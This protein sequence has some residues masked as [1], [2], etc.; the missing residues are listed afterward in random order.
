MTVRFLINRMTSKVIEV[1]FKKFFL[2]SPLFVIPP[3]IFGSIYFVHKIWSCGDK[4][5]VKYVERLL[6][7]YSRTQNRYKYYS[8]RLRKR[9]I[10]VDIIFHNQCH[11]I[12][13]KVR[14]FKKIHSMKLLLFLFLYQC[15]KKMKRKSF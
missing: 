11:F 5:D 15:S 4:L 12:L 13:L 3:K 9:F 14:K 8:P 1:H 7:D 10:S 6:L 2:D